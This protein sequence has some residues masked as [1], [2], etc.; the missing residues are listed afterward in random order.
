MMVGHRP[1]PLAGTT[2]ENDGAGL[3][4]ATAHPMTMTSTR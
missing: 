4:M 2:V 3:G 1:P